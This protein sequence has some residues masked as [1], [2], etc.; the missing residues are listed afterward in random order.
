VL[1]WELAQ[2]DSAVDDVFGFRAVQIGLPEVDFLRQNRIR[3]RFTLALEQGAALAADPLQLPLA[4]QSVDLVALPHV[5]EAHH[6][7]HDVLR[8]VERVLMPEGQAVISGFNT[9]SLWRLRQAFMFQ[10]NGAPWDAKFIGV[11]RLREWLRVLGFELNGGKFGCYAPP[12][13]DRRWLERFSFM[14]KAGA[15]WWP[16]TGGVYVVRAVKRVHGMRL[17]TPAWRQERARR[18]SLA[19]PVSQRSNGNTHKTTDG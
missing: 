18:R 4:S 6:N 5:L 9:V 14:E 2:F 7:P 12:F 11:L 10:R 3:Y 1:D 13:S 15:R 16:V 19:A 17:I 8:E